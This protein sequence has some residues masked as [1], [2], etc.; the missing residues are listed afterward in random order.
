MFNRASASLQL[1]RTTRASRVA[2]SPHVVGGGGAASK[3][4]DD[5]R[6]ASSSRAP[7]A[8]A[9]TNAQSAR[10]TTARSTPRA[11]RAGGIAR[12]C[13]VAAVRGGRVRSASASSSSSDAGKNR[14][15]VSGDEHQ[16]VYTTAC[17]ENRS[18]ARGR[19]G[20]GV[21]TGFAR[22]GW[23]E[24]VNNG[25]GV[26]ARRARNRVEDRETK[27]STTKFLVSSS[28]ISR[29]NADA[30]YVFFSAATSTGVSW[31]SFSRVVSTPRTRAD[32]TLRRRRDDAPTTTRTKTMTMTTKTIT[33]ALVCA[34]ALSAMVPTCFAKDV[35]WDAM[36]DAAAAP[37]PAPADDAAAPAPAPTMDGER[38]VVD[39]AIEDP[40]F[41]TL[42][43]AVVAVPEVLDTLETPGPWTVFAPSNEAIAT[44]LAEN[45]LTAEQLLASP[46]LGD[47]LKKHV[48]AGKLLAADAV[49]AVSAGPITLTTLNGDV[50]ARMVDGTLYVGGAAVVQVDI[51][52]D[53]GVVHVIDRVIQ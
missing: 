12:A 33:G 10:C 25:D 48:V 45:G 43:T 35:T 7:L 37:A 38:T 5:A 49:N 50:D 30:D 36:A 4:S 28:R 20:V 2:L 9:R 44:F 46:G 13:A 31:L 23:A 18:G 3:S 1:N 39:V 14:R 15:P 27:S 17:A 32:V 40:R 29:I 24:K 53:N 41:A 34:L 26:G 19:G 8:R 51:M 42:V 21:V 6:A 22:A 52:A 11:T 16:T 47:V